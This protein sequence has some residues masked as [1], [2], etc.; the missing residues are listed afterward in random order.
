MNI[1]VS[2]GQRYYFL[3]KD[4]AQTAASNP[5]PMAVSG[6]PDSSMN[7]VHQDLDTGEVVEKLTS[8]T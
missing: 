4:K 6:W 8:Y 5:P 1:T 7:A 2:A 3:L